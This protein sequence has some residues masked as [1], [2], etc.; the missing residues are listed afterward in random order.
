[1]MDMTAMGTGM[2][3]GMGVYHFAIVI[4]ALLGS[5]ASIKYLRS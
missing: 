2:M 5:A 4:F 1:M 3:V